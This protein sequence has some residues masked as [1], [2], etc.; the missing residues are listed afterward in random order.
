VKCEKT[1]LASSFL[2]NEHRFK[3]GAQNYFLASPKKIKTG[4]KT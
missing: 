2:K 3:N 4:A 1:A